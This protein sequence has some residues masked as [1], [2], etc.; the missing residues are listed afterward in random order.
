MGVN[1]E[2]K[3]KFFAIF[4]VVALPFT[5]A[6]LYAAGASYHLGYLSEFGVEG[7]LSYTGINETIYTGLFA[8]FSRIDLI[9]NIG[10]FLIV[11]FTFGL[12]IPYFK[13]FNNIKNV[14]DKIF[15]N[16]STVELNIYKKITMYFSLL[17]TAAPLFV[18]VIILWM[19]SI[20]EQGANVAIKQKNKFLKDYNL[21]FSKKKVDDPFFFRLNLA[22][23]KTNYGIVI[24]ENGTF[25]SFYTK[26]GVKIYPSNFV[27]MEQANVDSKVLS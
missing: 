25:V 7:E 21:W 14:F 22:N 19:Y 12:I 27:S 17:F 23:G 1:Q 20:H 6:L 18:A 26:S 2:I 13:S 11:I 4:L 24:A 3:N 9:Q 16:K 15:E 5:I 10:M 8:I